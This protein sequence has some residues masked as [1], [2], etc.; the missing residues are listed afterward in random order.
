MAVHATVRR[1]VPIDE[2]TTDQQFSPLVLFDHL[3][4]RESVTD[5]K[6]RGPAC[7]TAIGVATT[8][9]EMIDADLDGWILFVA[10]RALTTIGV[11]RDCGVSSTRSAADDMGYS[12]DRGPAEA[13]PAFRP[14]GGRFG[15][16]SSGGTVRRRTVAG[17]SAGSAVTNVV[18]NTLSAPEIHHNRGEPVTPWCDQA[19][20]GKHM[21]VYMRRCV[22]VV[23]AAAMSC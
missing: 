15:R 8:D 16:S 6:G 10:H 17:S 1:V 23:G 11:E 5:R 2:T 7:R 9:Q 22:H 14:V 4:A 3:V 13:G 19:D 21:C 12:R 20:S 18:E